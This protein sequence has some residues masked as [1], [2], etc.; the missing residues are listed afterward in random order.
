MGDIPAQGPQ[1]GTGTNSRLTA[2]EQR[3]VFSPLRLICL[4]AVS[5]IIIE[6]LVEFLAPYLPALPQYSW[7]VLDSLLTTLILFPLLFLYVFKPLKHLVADFSNNER[8]LRLARIN[9]EQQV[10]ERTASMLDAMLHLE[11]E[12]AERCQVERALQASEEL[13]RQIF[14]QS[15][16]AIIMIARDSNAILKINPVAERLFARGR[17]ELVAAG[18]PGLFSGREK[19]QLAKAIAE[20]RR[21]GL[22]VDLKQLEIRGAAGQTRILSFRGKLISLEGSQVIYTT[23]RDITRRVR[24]EEESKEI[25]AR[26]IHANRMTSLGMLVAS[27]AHEIN[28]PNNYILMNAS[29]LQ[30]SWND[31][32]RVLRQHYQEEGEFMIGQ[33]TFS[34]AAQFLPEAYDGIADGARRIREIVDNLKGHCRGDRGGLD[35]TADL[36]AVVRMSVSLMNHLISRTTNHFTLDLAPD[37]PPVRGS[38]H[39]LEQVAINLITNALQSLPDAEHGIRVSTALDRAEDKLLLRIEDQGGGIPEEIAGRVM[40]PFFTTRLDRGG[41]GLG[42]AICATIIND[43]GGSIRFESEPGKGTVFIVRLQRADRG[44]G[45]KSGMGGNDAGR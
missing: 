17:A 26:L 31:I 35:G 4:L 27:V 3:I 1:T 42:L 2:R 36:N 12:N 19:E 40:E 23:F 41:T 44:E 45:N 18:L 30:Q 10:A 32:H 6:I 24:L 20:I 43:H 9:L 13:F 28:N 14:E 34:E 16:D 7:Y 38:M 8:N 37:L 39:Q 33:A 11:K 25:Q 21:D 15:E 5:L 22:P 29:L